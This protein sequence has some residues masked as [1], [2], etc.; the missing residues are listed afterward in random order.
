MT[1]NDL[2]SPLSYLTTRR[3]A[4]PRELA[5][6]RPD[7]SEMRDFARIAAR[8]PDHGKLAPW[9]FTIV[10]EEQRRAFRALLESAFLGANPDARPASVEAACQFA[11][12]DAALM[13]ASFEPVDSAK[14]PRWEQELS[15]G[16]AVMNLCHAAHASGYVCGWVTGWASTD[17]IVTTEFCGDSGRI[18]GIVFIGSPGAPLEERPRPELDEVARVWEAKTAPPHS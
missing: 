11:D 3:S 13:I 10:P 14:I 2:S 6:R 12:Y 18:A 1:F 5:G 16:A 17:P 7:A 8:S 9:R 4:K 15:C